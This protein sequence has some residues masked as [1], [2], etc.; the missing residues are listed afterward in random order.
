MENNMDDDFGI[1]QN[2]ASAQAYKSVKQ[3]LIMQ[4][5]KEKLHAKQIQKMLVTDIKGKKDVMRKIA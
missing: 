3:K 5:Q 4:Q 2:N 1:Y